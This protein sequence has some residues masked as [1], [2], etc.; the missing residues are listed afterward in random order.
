[1][2]L[3]LMSTTIKTEVYILITRRQQRKGISANS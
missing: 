3:K 1:M 2:H